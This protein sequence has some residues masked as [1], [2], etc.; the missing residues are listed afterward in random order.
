MCI[1]YSEDIVFIKTH[2]DFLSYKVLII[3]NNNVFC[4]LVF[5]REW[6]E[7]PDKYR[8]MKVFKANLS[9]FL[10]FFLCSFQVEV[11]AQKIPDN[12]IIPICSN[13]AIETGAPGNS[14]INNIWT[15]CGSF[16]PLSPFLDFY[17]VKILQGTTFTFTV[18]PYG[19]DDY[20]FAAFLN[21]D[22]NDINNTP[23]AN[24]R[25]SQ[26][27]PFQTNRFGLGLSLTATD[28]CEPNGSSG[29]PEPGFVRYFDVNPGDEILIAI[30]RWSRTNRGYTMSFE[31]GDAVLDCTIVGNT[32]SKCEDFVG[33]TVE[34]NETDFLPELEA[35]Y[36]DAVFKFYDA[37]TEA[38]QNT[39][40]YIDFPI[41]LRYNDNVPHEIFVRIETQSGSF[42]KVL[43]QLIL[44]KP[45]P[46][47]LQ[48]ALQLPELCSDDDGRATFDLTWAEGTFVSDPANYD[49]MYFGSESDAVNEVN[50]ISNIRAFVTN[51]TS[52]FVRITSIPISEQDFVCST[53]A[54]L[55]LKVN[56]ATQSVDALQAC[57]SYMW[58]GQVLT[59]SG[60][61][62]AKFQ[63]A[64]GCDSLAI[65]HVTIFTPDLVT[66]N[67]D[68]C[69]S[70]TWD[71]ELIDQSG[72][73][74]HHFTNIN[75]CD[76]TE[77]LNLIVHPEYMFSDDVTTC[78]SFYWPATGQTYTQ[79]GIFEFATQSIQGC[80]SV[81]T[82]QLV[83]YPKYSA[84]EQ[85]TACDEFTWSLTGD[86]Y[87]SS[88]D[89]QVVMETV[90]GC[91]STF[92]LKLQVSQSFNS[93][94][95]IHAFGEY[96]WPVNNKTYNESGIY[97][98]SFVTATGCDSI[99]VLDLSVEPPTE[100]YFPN[101][102]AKGGANGVFTGYSNK[103]ILN[104]ISLSV[105]DRWGSMIFRNDNFPSNTPEEGW[106]ATLSGREVPIGVYIWISEV[107]NKEGTKSTYHGNVTVIR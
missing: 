50:A 83:I 69:G 47:L 86:T 106:N 84:I 28:V 96:T 26:N 79:S 64:K 17:Y 63:N 12:L 52:I 40:N 36:P 18:T 66:H 91:D 85:I 89:Y 78:G 27:D 15:P 13:Q 25:G 35:E 67:V 100:F 94:E 16:S 3:V 101:I 22:W 20:D 53:T 105:Y 88:G 41:S 30:D 60:T 87:T 54:R 104:I 81:G 74:E 98:A 59:N 70:Y 43:K 32:F 56:H 77:V 39:T 21:P 90:D 102:I 75:G 107:E 72:S 29:N 46:V 44:V 61:Y 62:E 9:L 51:D 99:Y 49:F 80:D 10:L 93:D 42:I 31:G 11:L 6:L 103:G 19:R 37:Q 73:Y 58:N 48:N 33:A 38:E 8:R 5:E 95:S 4:R 2:F 65:L 97:T 7:N 68:A 1:V 23:Y 92:T 71:N 76:S 82:L 34:F 14:G 55:D 45:F 57:S 24:K